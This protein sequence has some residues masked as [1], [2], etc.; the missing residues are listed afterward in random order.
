ML[1]QL[2][3]QLEKVQAQIKQLQ[4]DEH[5][6]KQQIAKANFIQKFENALTDE[7]CFNNNLDD[8]VKC[9][10]AEIAPDCYTEQELLE[11]SA[12]YQLDLVKITFHVKVNAKLGGYKCQD[13]VGTWK[14]MCDMCDHPLLKLD[15]IKYIN[16]IYEI[17]L[18]ENDLE[19]INESTCD[20]INDMS[21]TKHQFDPDEDNITYEYSDEFWGDSYA[22]AICDV[23]KLALITHYVE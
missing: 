5:N 13:I 9:S 11:L 10:Y 22:S 20:L 1:N 4:Q 12:K 6:I 3:D 8:Q 2:N 18:T 21:N 16:N 14:I 23:T 7:E 17:E 15:D 19:S